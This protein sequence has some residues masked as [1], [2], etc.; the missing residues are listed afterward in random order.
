MMKSRK[1]EKERKKEW[2]GAIKREQGIRWCT[3]CCE[4]CLIAAVASVSIFVFVDALRE[5]EIIQRTNDDKIIF[6]TQACGD[7]AAGHIYYYYTRY[8]YWQN[9]NLNKRL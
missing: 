3:L 5:Y 6:M 4:L 7:M 1:R 2:Q 9:A 8:M